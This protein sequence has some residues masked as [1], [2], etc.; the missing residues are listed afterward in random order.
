MPA[1]VSDER[2]NL[3]LYTSDESPGISSLSPFTEGHE[4]AGVVTVT[5]LRDYLAEHPEVDHVDFLKVDV[6]GYE[7]NVL[8]GHDWRFA[9]TA[10]VLEFEDR[11]TVPL[12]Y[13]WRDLADG[14]LSRGYGVIVSEWE[15][16]ATYGG[17]HEWQGFH[18]YPAALNDERAWGNLIATRERFDDLLALT[19]RVEG[20]YRRRGRFERLRRPR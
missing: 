7:A 5:T 4:A 8:R 17:S 3:T 10:V 19:T 13:S 11:K 20:R 6:E 14:L 15:A 18:P 1:A 12:G 16:D 9:P 2:G